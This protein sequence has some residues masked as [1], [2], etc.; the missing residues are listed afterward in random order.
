LKLKNS[1]CLNCDHYL[2]C[3]IY[4]ECI[5]KLEDDKLGITIEIKECKNFN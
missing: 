1:K 2:V 4:K 3:W 5:S